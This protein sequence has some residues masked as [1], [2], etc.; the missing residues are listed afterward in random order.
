MYGTRKPRSRTLKQAKDADGKTVKVG[1]KVFFKEDIEGEG[2]ILKI[3]VKYSSFGTSRTT[4]YLGNHPTDPTYEPWHRMAYDDDWDLKCA[5]VAT[6]T[7]HKID[8]K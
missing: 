1:E 7:V 3:E 6:T 8:W 5:V 2:C 4:F